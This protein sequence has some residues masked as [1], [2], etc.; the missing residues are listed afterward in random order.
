MSKKIKA[1]EALIAAQIALTGCIVTRDGA[2]CKLVNVSGSHR[3]GV[4]IPG[5]PVVM[6]LKPR[7][8]TRA[9]QRTV[10]VRESIRTSLV[11]EWVAGQMPSFLHGE[12]FAVVAIGRQV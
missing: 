8:A 5:A 3:G 2:P 12:A 7:D 11:A 10:R 9:I 1:E 6:F 4:L